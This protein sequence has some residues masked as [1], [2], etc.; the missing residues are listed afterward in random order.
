MV[1]KNLKNLRK[2]NHLTQQEL[3]DMLGVT[4]QAYS[5]YETGKRGLDIK[6]LIKI[7]DY[8]HV[9][10]DQLVKTPIEIYSKTGKIGLEPC[11]LIEF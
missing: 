10:L 8:Y 3:A 7:S 2:K 4:R 6:F 5:N 11:N 1:Y 9:T